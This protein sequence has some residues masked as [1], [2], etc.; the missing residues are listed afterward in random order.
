VL[1]DECIAKKKAIVK[2]KSNCDDAAVTKSSL[3]SESPEQIPESSSCV[4]DEE[5]AAGSYDREQMTENTPECRVEVRLLGI[6]LYS[7]IVL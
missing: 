7:C 5:T 3:T 1:A 4:Q 6:R 2:D